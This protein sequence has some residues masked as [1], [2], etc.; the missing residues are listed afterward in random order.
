M[1]RYKSKEFRELK[2]E[3]YQKAK[4]SGF[5]DA[6]KSDRWFS[7]GRNHRW[8]ALE[9]TTE[10]FLNKE[11]YFRRASHMLYEFTFESEVQ[12]EIWALHADGLTMREIAEQMRAKGKKKWTKDSVCAVI[13]KIRKHI[14][15]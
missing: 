13:K 10:E 1:T 4:D 9:Y 5:T 14:K 12:K 11:A 8:F 3:W 7:D 2:K 6:E 15:G